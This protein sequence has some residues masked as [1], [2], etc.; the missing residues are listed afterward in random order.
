MRKL[1]R[2]DRVQPKHPKHGN[3]PTGTWLGKCGGVVELWIDDA[4]GLITS[5]HEADYNLLETTWQEE[6]E[7]IHRGILGSGGGPTWLP[8]GAED[9]RFWGL[10]LCGEAGE[11]AN[12]IKKLWRGDSI[13]RTEILEEIADVQISLNQLAKCF[14]ADPDV[15]AACKIPVLYNRWPSIKPIE[16]E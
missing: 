13:A 14:N 8:Y 10:A 9:S 7:N 4:L 2:G 3:R 6:A 12:K 5:V 15:E 11:L 1:K 16:E